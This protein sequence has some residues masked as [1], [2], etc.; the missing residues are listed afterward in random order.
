MHSS[1]RQLLGQ[2]VVNLVLRYFSNQKKANGDK[3]FTKIVGIDDTAWADV[4][5]AFQ[6]VEVELATYFEPII[7]TL[8]KVNGFEAYQCQQYETSTWLRNN[9]SSGS[10]LLIFMN[11]DSPEAQSLENIFTIDEARLLS[12][13]GLEVLYQLFAETYKCY[14]D[15][16]KTLQ[17]FLGMYNRIS[18]PQLR[19]IL[20]FL[21]A[22]IDDPE[23]SM[24]DKIQRNLDQLLLFRDSK[25]SFNNSDGLT[26]LKRNYQLSRLEKEGKASK[27]DDFIENLFEFI[28]KG[29]GDQDGHELWERV[30]PDVF[31]QQALDFIHNQST[32]LFQYEYDHVVTALLFKVGKPKLNERVNEFKMTIE[33]Q[34]EWSQDKNKLLSEALEA[35]DENRN[36]DKIQEFIDELSF[37]L[38]G[39]PKL[40]KD[41]ERT[42]IRLR[43]LPEYT[44]LSEA[45]LR[46]CILLLEEYSDDYLMTSVEFELRIMD[47]QVSEQMHAALQFHL[48]H[49]EQLTGR[50]C[51]NA[52]TLIMSSE[53]AKESDISLQL[54]MYVEGKEIDKKRFKLVR[55]FSGS[56]SGMISHVHDTGR[57]PYVQ[58]YFG[59]DMKLIDVIET[60]KDNVSGYVAVNDE[61]V[62]VAVDI[63]CEFVDYYTEE[64]LG[65]LHQGLC[66]LDV[67]QLE[68]RLEI[69]LQH[70]H[71]SALISKHILQY[72]SCLGAIDRY[73]CKIYEPVGY[74]QDRILTLL[75]PLRL[76]SYTKRIVHIK[77][78]LQN[79]IDQ[80]QAS[81]NAVDEMGAYLQQL[82]EETAHLSPHYFAIDGV[83][84]QYLIEQQERMGEG[85][86][87]LNGKSSGE[88]QFVD[89]FAGEFLYTV[90]TYLDV[91]PYARDCL[92]IVFLYCPHAEYVT[93]AID[94]IFKHTDVRK[95]KA[96]IHS[97]TKGAAIH[98]Y[99]N[100]WINQ[101]EQYSERYFSFPRVE[102]Q[103]VAEKQINAMMQS[104][105]HSL[106][107]ADLGILVNYFGQTTHIQYKLEKVHV[108]DSDNWFDTIYR[109]PLKKDDAIKRVS[110]ISEK[111]PKLMQFFYR[112]QY[113]LHSSEAISSDEHYLL[114]TVISITHHSDAKLI[115]YMHDKFNWSLFIDRHL[116]KSLL[117]QVSSKAQIIKYKSRVGK[118]KDFRTLL[119]SSKYIRKL[120]NE[121]DDHAY[122]DRLHQKYVKLL[123]NGNIDKQ[124]IVKATE[125]VKEISG[126]VVLRAIG[127]GK[128][129]HELMAMYL[130]TEARLALDGELVI[131]SVC[132]ELP[133][134]QGSVRRPDLVRTSI[135][136]NESRISIQFELVELKFISHTIFETER[137]DA[138]KQVKAGLELY[139]S[140]FMFNEH[141]ASA[142][143]WRKELIY[144]LL[145]YGTYSV[146]DA[147]LLKELQGI[148]IN[149]IDVALSGSID[150]FVY[151]SNL[152]ELSVMEGH[153]DGYQ[154]ELL[155]N[156]F[157]N[158]I[159]NRSYILR[160][161]GAA[162]ESA[163]P[164]YE[165][166]QNLEVF[167]NDKI[168]QEQVRELVAEEPI[169]ENDT[170]KAV[171]LEA[172]SLFL[173]A[174]G[175][176]DD[177]AQADN[178]AQA[179]A[180]TLERSS[181]A[182]SVAY[183]EQ[184]ALSGD[185]LMENPLLEDV[186]PLVENYQ[187]KLRFGF[188]QIGISIKIVESFVGVSVIRMIVE[189]PNDK[190]YSSIEKKA[191][192]IYLW[193][194]LSSI[195]L[196]AL[197][198][199][200]INID[201]NRDTPEIVYFE[202]FMKQTR[203]LYPPS[204]LKGKLIAPIGVG[205]LR[206]LIVM[207]FSSPNTPHLLIGG[208]TGSGKSVTI[209]S[210]ILAMMCMYDPSEV[211]F[212]FID[213]KKVEFL[214]YENRS[215]TKQVI[216]EIEEAIRALEQLVEDMEQR[217]LMLARESVS[218]IDEYV[219]VT[220]IAMPRI[221]MVFDEFADF[222]EREK[223]LSGRVENAIL[224]LG[225]K[226]RAAGI[227]LLICTQNPKADIVPTNIRNNLP[228]R[229]ALKAADHH[230]SKI[231][232]NEDGAEKLGGKGDFL[233]KLDSPET[234]RAKS[235]YLT[236][237][238]KR[239][240]LQYF[241]KN[242]EL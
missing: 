69:V 53:K 159:Y 150:T 147:L 112:M 95:V 91:Y 178:P 197:R 234:V 12:A 66:S 97:E 15:E 207:D 171:G 3:L 39:A 105:S 7:R 188:N 14:G 169:K 74:V 24:V 166:L 92:D 83:P 54:H 158:H 107:D 212:M 133:W 228:A 2:W 205:Q 130:S 191:E 170:E 144:Y 108:K 190:S 73:D 187:R 121:Q 77:T 167:V 59:S 233:V 62:K 163:I 32:E 196:I 23:L 139:R 17:V 45:L 37:E 180:L 189:I 122:Y 90:K 34:D 177:T 162:Q 236:P 175:R 200:R 41:L 153:M 238:V 172:N 217:Y 4:L 220:G 235:P 94:Q 134:F 126:G 140:R 239:A 242:E 182:S 173:V 96:I 211:Q 70:A 40:R 155:N 118:N 88:E 55:A 232:I 50:I 168:G 146:E 26:R 6:K 11:N 157:T 30:K 185:P 199:G 224:R 183:P 36:P 127:P 10:A 156:D 16:L 84:D 93:S 86:F 123:Q 237:R 141:P 179:S 192:D 42:I 210:I 136:R 219:E 103:V 67:Y 19:N 1:G 52:S 125:R 213:P 49:L 181:P 194:Q 165:E 209:N 65:A 230:A 148:P 132:D 38:Q 114:R 120:A 78:E 21:A 9:T 89:T 25:L 145:E 218:S 161:L 102:I 85:T 87:V 137:Y 216:T 208:T 198:N 68:A 61:G 193:L 44:E 215:H 71:Q 116:D 35:I 18:E 124:T 22:I 106:L 80:Q 111:L 117:R 33:D 204:R 79:W 222:M 240:L 176:E 119:S 184:I 51:F 154:T 28:G 81:A 113:V 214:T 43:Q 164:E 206:E 100:G 27:K 227:H 143:L 48:L 20:A 135:R 226:A 101:E 241:N 151:T 110:L 46:E 57:V 129:A 131:W 138:I 221:V 13:E 152:L 231:I 47:A 72:I 60:V 149:H 104:V 31:R 63:F 174:V 98:E 160:A 75:N 115:D 128:F 56:L 201:I 142:E 5:H 82:Q 58:E 76:L 223:S 8:S 195:P 202:N 109:E 186:M 229:L 64:L 203:E 225:A 29:A 99:L